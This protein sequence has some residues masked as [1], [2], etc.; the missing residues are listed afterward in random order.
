MSVSHSQC[1]AVAS[2]CN[3]QFNADEH[4]EFR[5]KN[6]QIP[7]DY[8]RCKHRNGV[9]SFRPDGAHVFD[10]EVLNEK[11]DTMFFLCSDCSVCPENFL[12]KPAKVRTC[13]EGDYEFDPTNPTHISMLIPF[14]NCKARQSGNKILV[15]R[16]VHS[17]VGLK[18][19]PFNTKRINITCKRFQRN[20]RVCI[21]K[22][23]K[24]VMETTSME[25]SGAERKAIYDAIDLENGKRTPRKEC[26][27]MMQITIK[28]EAIEDISS[29]GC[30]ENK[31]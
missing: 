21:A 7:I 9:W 11:G 15:H 13:N 17:F 12:G 3:K 30:T 23:L 16:G 26:I 28:D 29:D 1:G 31:E 24:P 20:K 19:R 2:L 8:E 4:N 14:L 5:R 10:H 22:L 18:K 27:P 25:F 6:G